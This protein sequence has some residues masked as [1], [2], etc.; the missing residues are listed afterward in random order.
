[1]FI[2]ADLL[3]TFVMKNTMVEQVHITVVNAEWIAVCHAIT[4]L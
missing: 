3:V 4:T 1:M 2:L